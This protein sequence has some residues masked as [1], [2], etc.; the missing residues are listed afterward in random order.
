MNPGIAV[1]AVAGLLTLAGCETTATSSPIGPKASAWEGPVFVTQYPLPDD[2]THKVLGTVQADAQAG[3]DSVVTLY[4]LLAAE[5]RKMGANAVV[6]AKGA[7]RVTAFS[8]AAAYVTGTAVKV[9]DPQKL[10]NLPGTYH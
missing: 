9:D 6:S 2:V 3:Y 5:A 1:V 8:W 10:K 4:P 7:R